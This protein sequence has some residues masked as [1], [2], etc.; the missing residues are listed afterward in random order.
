MTTVPAHYSR[1]LECPY[2][3]EHKERQPNL[4]VIRIKD[5][6]QKTWQ[7]PQNASKTQGN[8]SS[9]L[10]STTAASSAVVL[11]R[12]FA[13]S[14][15]AVSASVRSPSREKFRASSSRAG[16]IRESVRGLQSRTCSRDLISASAYG[17]EVWT[18]HPQ[19][20][21]PHVLAPET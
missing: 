12:S 2:A 20:T 21:S 19:Q 16:R 13:S 5:R 11:A 7:L 6:E 9:S 15:Y 8:R 10:A 14:A 3:S 4:F 17:A 18:Y 1:A